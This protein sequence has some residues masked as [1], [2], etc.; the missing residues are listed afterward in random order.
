LDDIRQREDGDDLWADE[1][2]E[3]GLRDDEA[4]VTVPVQQN[5]T[6]NVTEGVTQTGPA[7]VTVGVTTT[8]EQVMGDTV[9]IDGM[10]VTP[11]HVPLGQMIAPRTEREAAELAAAVAEFYAQSEEWP[12]ER[13]ELA[14]WTTLKKFTGTPGVRG[15][16]VRVGQLSQ[17]CHRSLAWVHDRMDKGRREGLI[18]PVKTGS[19]YYRIA[20]GRD[21][22]AL[23]AHAE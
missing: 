7:D 23:S 12:T 14:F 21:I 3:F 5:V 17:E 18:V 1:R 11:V 6:Q 15:P 20:D 19:P 4:G 22:P 10:E 8:K 2:A 13:A 16:G 9:E